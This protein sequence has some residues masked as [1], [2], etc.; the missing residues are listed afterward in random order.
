LKKIGLLIANVQF[1][2]IVI[3]RKLI[4]DFNMMFY[5]LSKASINMAKSIEEKI[6]ELKQKMKELRLQKK[7]TPKPK[8]ANA[9]RAALD[10]NSPEIAALLN[11]IDNAADNNKVKVAEIIKLVS[12][13]KRTGLKI[14]DRARKVTKPT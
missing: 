4:I 9:S 13:L 14:G 3:L 6:A 10:K 8:A 11:L 7:Q 1:D 5:F 2:N 12:R